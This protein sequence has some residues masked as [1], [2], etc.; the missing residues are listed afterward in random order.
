MKKSI[1]L[2]CAFALAAASLAGCYGWSQNQAVG[3]GFGSLAGGGLGAII[4]HGNVGATLG[5][6]ALGGGAG[7]L[8]S[9]PR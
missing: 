8:V 6:A 4:S 1:I 2:K 9:S 7:Y 3:T 5:G